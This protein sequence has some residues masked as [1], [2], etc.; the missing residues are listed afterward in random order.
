MLT[1]AR[2]ASLP[3]PPLRRPPSA[4][5]LSSR[6]TATPRTPSASGTPRRTSAPTSSTPFECKHPGSHRDIKAQ[7]IDADTLLVAFDLEP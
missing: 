3:R 2:L 1:D 7:P 5:A 4:G 6:P